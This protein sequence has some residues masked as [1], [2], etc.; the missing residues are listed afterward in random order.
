M[1]FEIFNIGGKFK[2]L[3]FNPSGTSSSH[4]TY[5]DFVPPRVLTR[6]DFCFR[7]S[8]KKFHSQVTSDTYVFFDTIPSIRLRNF[9]NFVMLFFSNSSVFPLP[10][11]FCQPPA[12]FSIQFET[13]STWNLVE[14]IPRKRSIFLIADISKPARVFILQ[15]NLQINFFFGR[16]IKFL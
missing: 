2:N 7:D 5:P 15:F 9:D 12:H 13:K 14:V 10:R 1:S 16:T 11:E 8:L 3:Y 4:F 6:T